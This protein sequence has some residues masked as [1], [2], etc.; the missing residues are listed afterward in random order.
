MVDLRGF[1]AE[2]KRTRQLC[3]FTQQQVSDRTG[4][5]L[6][7]LRRWEQGKHEPDVSALVDLSRL[8][9]V[10]VG[11]LIGVEDGPAASL[12]PD[13]ARL[14]RLYRSTDARGRAAIMRTAEGEAGVERQPASG[15][16][17]A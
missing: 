16:V 2:Y 3:G 9:G 13:E 5:P 14:L 7:T 15:Q 12:D 4:I 17:I 11:Q 8:Y 10:T 6:G 1:K